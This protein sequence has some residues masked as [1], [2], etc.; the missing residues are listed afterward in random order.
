LATLMNF[1][2]R[3]KAWTKSIQHMPVF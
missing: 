3:S 1:T 2:Q